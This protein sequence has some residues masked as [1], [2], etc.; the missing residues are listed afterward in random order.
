MASLSRT[1][2]WMSLVSNKTKFPLLLLP[3]EIRCKV[4]RCTWRDRVVFVPV[5]KAK[6]PSSL[7]HSN[8]DPIAQ[9]QVPGRV[10]GRG[11]PETTS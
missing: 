1:S 3:H 6:L 4:W 8:M 7:I 11:N 2:E 5:G 9:Y 10:S